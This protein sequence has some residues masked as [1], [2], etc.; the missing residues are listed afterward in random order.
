MDD[1]G[2]DRATV[3]TLGQTVHG[4]LCM[5]RHV[6]SSQQHCVLIIFIDTRAMTGLGLGRSA[7]KNQ[8]LIQSISFPSE[9]VSCVL[10]CLTISVL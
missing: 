9:C 2:T 5:H 4:A 8:D 6:K 1:T 3:I 7:I 10:W